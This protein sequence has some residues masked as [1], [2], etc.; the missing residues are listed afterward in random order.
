MSDS[1]KIEK[2]LNAGW[3][4][5]DCGEKWFPPGFTNFYTSLDGAWETFTNGIHMEEPIRMVDRGMNKSTNNPSDE[6]MKR[7]PPNG[8]YEANSTPGTPC[9]CKETCPS[10]CK[11]GCGCEACSEA[12]GDY[13]S[14]Q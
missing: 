6:G 14:S 10:D 9:T 4:S 7:Y 8:R 5:K 2:L 11:G 12:Y 13:L 3:I 1:Q